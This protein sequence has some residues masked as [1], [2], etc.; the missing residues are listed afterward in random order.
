MYRLQN[1]LIADKIILNSFSQE[2]YRIHQDQCTG[3]YKK[4]PNN[5]FDPLLPRFLSRYSHIGLIISI[6][7]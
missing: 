6:K 7:P 2:F 3:N 1:K 4:K 5:N